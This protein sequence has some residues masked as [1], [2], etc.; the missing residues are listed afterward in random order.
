L[1]VRPGGVRSRT[2]ARARGDWGAHAPGVLANLLFWNALWF[3]LTQAA[4]SAALRKPIV[5][6]VF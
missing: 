4:S 2:V 5:A 6:A 1:Q 3:V